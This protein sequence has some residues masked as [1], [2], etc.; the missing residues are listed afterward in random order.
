MTDQPDI[1]DARDIC[2]LLRAHGE[3]HWLIAQ[4][5]PVLRQIEQPD[6]IPD[7]QL[8]AALAYLEI[9]W[10]DARRRAAGTDAACAQLDLLD[11]DSDRVLYDRARRYHAAVRRLRVA[12]GHR[13]TR[14]TRLGTDP[15]AMSTPGSEVI[16]YAHG[17]DAALRPPVPF[18]PL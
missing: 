9:L 8:G 18:D 7:D 17:D 6:S 1:T 3:Q 12:V 10:L 14:L 5:V 11:R 4:V 16:A 2:L 15:S 13:V